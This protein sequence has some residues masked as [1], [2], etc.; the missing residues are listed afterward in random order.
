MKDR[1]HGA[2]GFR[3]E[4][5]SAATAMIKESNNGLVVR[6]AAAARPSAQTHQAAGCNHRGRVKSDPVMTPACVV[7]PKRRPSQVR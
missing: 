3:A 6:L 4:T 5:T 2:S 7:T 1:P